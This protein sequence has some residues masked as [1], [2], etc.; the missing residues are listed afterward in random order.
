MKTWG[1]NGYTCTLQWA[2]ND[3]F[4]KRAAA[5]WTCILRENSA[6]FSKRE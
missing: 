2:A 3:H 1:Y 5:S 6:I 4:Q